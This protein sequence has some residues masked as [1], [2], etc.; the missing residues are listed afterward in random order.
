MLLNIIS[1]KEITFSRNE[2]K[3]N[4]EYDL[5]NWVGDLNVSFNA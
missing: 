1:G 5:M 2:D 3:Q 4:V